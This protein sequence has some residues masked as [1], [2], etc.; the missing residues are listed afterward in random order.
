M[1]GVT[2]DT[3]GGAQAFYTRSAHG[4][5]LA[6]ILAEEIQYLPDRKAVKPYKTN[7]GNTLKGWQA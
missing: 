6:D 4:K 2:P 7:M 5:E 3:S 1:A